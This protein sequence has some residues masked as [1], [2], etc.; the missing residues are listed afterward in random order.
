MV[1]PSVTMLASSRYS[2]LWPVRHC[3]HAARNTPYVIWRRSVLALVLTKIDPL[4]SIFD[5]IIQNNQ[6]KSS[7]SLKRRQGLLVAVLLI[8][9]VS[10]LIR[11]SFEAPFWK[12]ISSLVRFSERK[13]SAASSSS[14]FE[15]FRD[16]R[17]ATSR[18]IF[19][20]S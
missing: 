16:K 12:S 3:C 5:R 7:E 20:C 8:C 9:L 15:S 2:A 6:D 19:R 10:Y 1:G 14:A 4:S 13:R 18:I 17:A 11:V